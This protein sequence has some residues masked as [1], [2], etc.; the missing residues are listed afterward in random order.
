LFTSQLNYYGFVH[1]RSFSATG[2]STTALWINQELAQ[3]EVNDDIS[4]VLK[5]RRVEP[6]ETAK[7]VEGRRQRKELAIHTVE[8]DI[9]LDAKK[10]QM[11]QIRSMAIRGEEWGHTGGCVM[12]SSTAEECL[13]GFGIPRVVHVL[14][15]NSDSDGN[16]DCNGDENDSM[17]CVSSQGETST[18]AANMLLMLARSSTTS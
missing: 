9:G 11:D 18:A 4:A 3:N 16:Q 2:S 12:L 17:F 6:C 10:L 8:E 13:H 1:V 14:S 15:D 7:T 5:L